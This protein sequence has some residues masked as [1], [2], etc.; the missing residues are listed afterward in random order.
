MIPE[1]K[2]DYIVM[3]GALFVSSSQSQDTIPV[4]TKNERQAYAFGNK[5]TASKC[6]NYIDGKLIEVTTTYLAVDSHNIYNN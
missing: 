5:F 4:F 6:A 1:E 3:L 2:T